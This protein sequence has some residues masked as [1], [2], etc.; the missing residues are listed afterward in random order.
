MIGETQAKWEDAV[1]KAVALDPDSITIYQME[2][3]HNTAIARGI[4]DEGQASPVASWDQRRAWADFALREFEVAGYEINGAYTV[5]KPERNAGFIYRDALWRG[6]DMV[7]TG[8]ASFSHLSGVHYQNA[9][10][11]EGYV[12]PLARGELPLSRALRISDQERLTRE[13]VLQLKLGEVP[14]DYFQR[15][16]GQDVLQVFAQPLS[17]LGRD[18]FATLSD[19][20]VMLTRAGLLRVDA[21]LPRFFDPKY[22]D[23]RYT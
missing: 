4:K 2:V 22:T 21:L 1:A 19:G 18:G 15:K 11:W 13:F 10:S 3:P 12:E 7:G 6:A 23:I 17:S 20:K 14:V 8:V 5:V 9:D 16:F